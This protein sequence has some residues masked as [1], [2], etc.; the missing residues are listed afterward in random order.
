MSQIAK[1]LSFTVL[2]FTKLK[3]SRCSCDFLEVSQEAKSTKQNIP[4][5]SYQRKSTKQNVLNKIF[6]KIYYT[7]NKATLN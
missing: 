2:S 1:E 5:K 7:N 3:K 6:T 4:K